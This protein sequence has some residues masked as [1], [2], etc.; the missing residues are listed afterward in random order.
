MS[1]TVQNSPRYIRYRDIVLQR[2]KEY[3]KKNKEKIKE[4]ARNRYKNLSQEEK[5]KLAESR[6]AWLNRQSE[7]KQNEMRRK[8]R[9]YAK[10]RYHNHIVVISWICFKLIRSCMFCRDLTHIYFYKILVSM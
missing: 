2:V 10:N 4:Y 7:E 3:N 8:A 1:E 9:E 6:R 5:N